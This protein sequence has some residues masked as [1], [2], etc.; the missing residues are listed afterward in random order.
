MVDGDVKPSMTFLYGDIQ[1]AKKEIIVGIGNL[2]RNV[3]L[4]V[5]SSIME[6]IDRKMKKRLDTPLHLAAYFLNPYYSY[7]DSSIFGDGEVMDGFISA[8]ETFYHGD[9]DKQNQV[10]NEDLHKFKDQGGHFAKSV[11]MAG[12]KD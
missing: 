7:N 5:Y 1:K 10:L 6:I 2:D 11:A 8:I 12:C 9:Y 3:N 4:N